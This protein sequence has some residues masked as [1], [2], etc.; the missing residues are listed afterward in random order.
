MRP[1]PVTLYVGDT[2][3]SGWKDSQEGFEQNIPG[4][5]AKRISVLL[6]VIIN[7]IHTV[8]IMQIRKR[9][10]LKIH[11]HLW[12]KD[13]FRFAFCHQTLEI[14]FSYFIF[15]FNLFFILV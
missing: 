9:P 13:K 4:K 3:V 15:S 1:E 7:Q 6:R 10:L 12:C 11:V 5:Q 14:I 8:I 2:E